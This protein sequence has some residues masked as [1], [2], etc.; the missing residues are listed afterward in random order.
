[1]V[2]KRIYEFLICMAFWWII[3]WSF[4]NNMGGG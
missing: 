4:T 1:M 3:G 2:L